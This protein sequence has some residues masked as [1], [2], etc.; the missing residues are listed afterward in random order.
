MPTTF[1]PLRADR[2]NPFDRVERLSDIYRQA[3]REHGHDAPDMASTVFVSEPSLND[4][5]PGAHAQRAVERRIE[6]LIAEEALRREQMDQAPHAPARDQFAEHR[7]RAQRRWPRPVCVF[8][9]DDVID[10]PFRELP[11][12]AP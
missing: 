2:V 6:A 3:Y 5:L 12:D 9:D 4:L 7:A 10:V 8:G 1:R 11:R